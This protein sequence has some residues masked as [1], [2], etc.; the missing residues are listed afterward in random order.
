MADISRI[1]GELHAEVRSQVIAAI[2][3]AP[4]LSPA[5]QTLFAQALERAGQ[6]D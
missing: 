2:K 3:R 1:K 4:T 6:A 5:E